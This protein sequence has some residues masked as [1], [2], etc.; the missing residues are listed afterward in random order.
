MLRINHVS[1]A[2]DLSRRNALQMSLRFTAQ[3]HAYERGQRTQN[4]MFDPQIVIQSYKTNHLQ[5]PWVDPSK[6]LPIRLPSIHIMMLWTMRARLKVLV[7]LDPTTV[8]LVE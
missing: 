8:T 1:L 6:L 7:F 2:V 3:N 5:L 4:Y